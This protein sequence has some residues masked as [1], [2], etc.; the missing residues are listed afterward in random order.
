MKDTYPSTLT[1]EVDRIPLRNYLRA[2]RLLLWILS[3]SFFGVMLGLAA[4]TGYLERN[5]LKGTD[6]I[7]GV[8]KG[9]TA[10]LG[11][12][13]AIALTVYYIFSH[14]G[15]S[16]YANSLEVTVEGAFLRI[17]Q[18]TTA[19]T[20]RK[21]HF[22]SIVDYATYQDALMRRFG[23]H[24]LHMMTTGGGP[25]SLVV[26]PAVKNCEEVRDMLSEIDRLRENG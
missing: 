5:D 13:W 1:I 20:D 23:I 17:R 6:A 10:G 3:L 2:S 24:A 19:R 9:V 16:R 21:L 7:L 26:I 12:S 4:G 15:T 18:H 14:R 11:I 25:G 22:R 8:I